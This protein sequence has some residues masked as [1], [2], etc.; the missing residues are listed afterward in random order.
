MTGGGGFTQDMNVRFRQ[1]RSLL[2]GEGTYSNFDKSYITDHMVTT[3]KDRR[4]ATIFFKKASPEYYIKLKS[5]LKRQAERSK[6]SQIVLLLTLSAA[7]LI[8]LILLF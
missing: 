8:G 1:N 2:K 6:R 3:K 4:A 5:R 7:G